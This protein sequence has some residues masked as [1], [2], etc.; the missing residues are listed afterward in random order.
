MTPVPKSVSQKNRL[1]V[2]PASI[3]TC[4]KKNDFARKRRSRFFLPL[5][6]LIYSGNSRRIVF[7]VFRSPRS[8]F[9]TVMM[10]K[11]A[12]L[13][14]WHGH[15]PFYIC[16]FDTFEQLLG[17]VDTNGSFLRNFI[18]EKLCRYR[19]SN[20]WPSG[21]FPLVPAWTLDC[22]RLHQLI[23]STLGDLRRLVAV[24]SSCFRENKNFPFHLHLIALS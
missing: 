20:Q 16:T 13:K 11:N 12:F 22:F 17:V 6:F 15:E 19:Y 9:R 14:V 2:N 21:Q 18:S 4:K 5:P 1:R 24:D 10:I 23:A 3:P 7:G 8:K